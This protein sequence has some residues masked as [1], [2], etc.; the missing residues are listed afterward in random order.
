MCFQLSVTTVT[1]QL[2][3]SSTHDFFWGGGWDGSGQNHL[4][5]MLVEL[6]GQLLGEAGGPPPHR[7]AAGASTHQRGAL[8]SKAQQPA[9]V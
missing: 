7:H 9:S 2:V 1:L 3:E 5:R 8:G 4:G 6:R